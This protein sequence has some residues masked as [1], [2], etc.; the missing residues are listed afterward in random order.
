MLRLT[1]LEYVLYLLLL[2][3]PCRTVCSAD[4]EKIKNKG[5]LNEFI[6][7]P[8]SPLPGKDKCLQHYN[9][10]SQTVLQERVDFGVMTRS[11][12]QELGISIDL[13]TTDEGCRKRENVTQ[14]TERS[15]TA[16]MIYCY[17]PCGVSLGHVECIHAETCTAFPLLLFELFG[18]KPDSKD[19]TGVVIDRGLTYQSGIFF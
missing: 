18:E 8:F 16:G 14:R 5:K 1:G 17:R 6:A 19:L 15:K 13:L 7:C 11:K 12:R 4:V 10:E 9:N 2:K 3:I